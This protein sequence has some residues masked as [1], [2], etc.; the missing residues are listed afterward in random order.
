V[1]Q[2]LPFSVNT[3]CKPCFRI[4][5]HV[6]FQNED[7]NSIGGSNNKQLHRPFLFIH[8]ISMDSRFPVV[9]IIGRKF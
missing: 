9:T 6:L 4:L 5:S 3:T 7:I 1:Q 8:D 2:A